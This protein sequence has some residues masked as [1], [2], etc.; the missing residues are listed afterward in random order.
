VSLALDA[1]G[2]TLPADPACAEW[3]PELVEGLRRL[4]TG[5]FAG[6]CGPL[7]AALR[8]GAP[9]HWALRG[10]WES[11]RAVGDARAAAST[12]AALLRMRRTDP[13]TARRLA[14]ETNEVCRAAFPG[15]A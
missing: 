5:D 7:E 15:P 1:T 14:L 9:P 11:A 13:E 6:A 4:R 2:G 8:H 10:L 12:H 3:E